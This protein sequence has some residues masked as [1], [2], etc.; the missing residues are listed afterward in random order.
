MSCTFLRKSDFQVYVLKRR[1]RYENIPFIPT[2]TA[3]TFMRDAISQE[4]YRFQ[5]NLIHNSACIIV[6]VFIG[7]F[8]MYSNPFHFVNTIISS[9]SNSFIVNKRMRNGELRPHAALL[10]IPSTYTY[11]FTRNQ[12]CLL[13]IDT[14]Q[15]TIRYVSV[16]SHHIFTNTCPYEV[17]VLV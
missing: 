2:A 1:M 7:M 14:L 6:Y 13:V 9:K 11:W 16:L 8:Y 5:T 4:P 17:H 15:S 12:L 10:H 3:Q